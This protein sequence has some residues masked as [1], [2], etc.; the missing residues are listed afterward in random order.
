MTRTRTLTAALLAALALAVAGCG[1]SNSAATTSHKQ[2]STGSG[3]AATAST[4]ATTTQTATTTSTTAQT[5]TTTSNSGGVPVAGSACTAADLTPVFLNSN[6]ATGHVVMAFV[7]KNTGS[8]SCHTYGYPGVAFLSKSGAL[9]TTDATRTTID[10]AGHLSESAIT[11]APGQE[12]SFRMVTSDV[13][14][15]QSDCANAYGLQVIAPDDSATM[16]TSMP[17]AI[18]FCDGKATVSPLVAGTGAS[19]T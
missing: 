9:L 5:T 11:L 7:L 15:S 12:A 3:Q 1:G 8:A 17:E 16:K 14:S 10:F 6:G 4:S 19:S 18:S 2:A 13:G